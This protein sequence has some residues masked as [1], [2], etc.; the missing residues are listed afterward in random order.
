MPEPL[1]TA[2]ANK[3]VNM[4]IKKATSIIQ[5]MHSTIELNIKQFLI[6]DVQLPPNSHCDR[7]FKNFNFCSYLHKN[8][9]YDALWHINLINGF[10]IVCP[11]DECG[12]RM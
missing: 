7:V 9:K 5:F 2:V 10:L 3:F 4:K 8:V 1:S 11:K 12:A 6:Y